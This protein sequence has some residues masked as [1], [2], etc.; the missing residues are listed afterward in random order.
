MNVATTTVRRGFVFL[1][2]LTSAVSAPAGL[3][4]ENVDLWLSTDIRSAYVSSGGSVVE[5]RPVSAQF[6]EGWCHLGEGGRIGAYFWIVSAW[7]DQRDADRR[8]LF[9][10][11]ETGLQYA[12]DYRFTEALSLN[13][14]I[15][16]L[17]N[18][19]IGYDSYAANEIDTI[20]QVVEAFENPVV[21]PYLDFRYAYHPDQ[22]SQFATGLRRRFD[23]GDGRLAVTPFA[24][25]IWGD[26]HRYDNKYGKSA[27]PSF[28]F[29]GYIPMCSLVG[30][31]C[32]YKISSNLQVYCHLQ[33]YDVIDPD[34]RRQMRKSPKDWVVRDLPIGE[35]GVALQ[36]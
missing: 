33:Q 16:N 28:R 12:Y 15:V 29:C 21:T 36:F 13:T 30:V 34:G 3:L 9:N 4:C 32:A 14:Q 23:F 35:V 22:W 6:L 11:L 18:P 17:W 25:L 27:D 10:E 7:S 5:T 8:R 20:V 19:C 26:D 24:S 1:S 2:L 31:R